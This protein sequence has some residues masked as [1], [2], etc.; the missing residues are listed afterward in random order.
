MRRL[1]LTPA[2]APAESVIRV[3]ESPFDEKVLQP[4]TCPFC[5][6][7]HVDPAVAAIVTAKTSW[8][9]RECDRTWTIAV[10]NRRSIVP[11]QKL[12]A[13]PA[14][15]LCPSCQQPQTKIKRV[16]TGGKFGS[17]QFV[18]SRVDCVR[19]IDLAKLETWVAD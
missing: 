2:L 6:G 11:K 8:R 17:T 3:R 16:L 14:A 18:C 12:P 15:H 13:V 19:A 5:N 9:C 1:V 4:K 10:H 7:G